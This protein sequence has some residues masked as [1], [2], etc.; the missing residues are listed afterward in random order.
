MP[1]FELIGPTGV[2]KTT[3]AQAYLRANAEGRPCTPAELARGQAVTP[4]PGPADAFLLGRLL[5]RLVDQHKGEGN[6]FDFYHR[7]DHFYRKLIQDAGLR[8]HYATRSV[9]DD[10]PVSHLFL[11][12]LLAL[13]SDEPRFAEFTRHRVYIFVENRVEQVLDN[14]ARRAARTYRALNG[15][16]RASLESKIVA[17]Y[18]E[19]M[20]QFKAHLGK[21]SIQHFEI[22]LT[23]GLTHGVQALQAALQECAT[24]PTARCPPAAP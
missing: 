1:I 17:P 8:H 10:D 6:I 7:L 15:F 13:A 24:S 16:S 20:S 19:H 21:K 3:L 23:L 11:A 5:P 9:L 14:H 12:D 18:R 2:G 22:D 4:R